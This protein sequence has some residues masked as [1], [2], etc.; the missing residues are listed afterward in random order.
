MRVTIVCFLS[1]LVFT[2]VAATIRTLTR[3]TPIAKPSF[4][5]E[6]TEWLREHLTRATGDT[7]LLGVGKADIT[8]CVDSP[9][10]YLACTNCE[11]QPRC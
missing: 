2:F 8:G 6:N 3:Q 1:F 10:P 11:S 4:D 7:Y 5:D 9:G